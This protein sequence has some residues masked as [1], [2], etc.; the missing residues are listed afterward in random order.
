MRGKRTASVHLPTSR[1]QGNCRRKRK[2]RCRLRDNN[3]STLDLIRFRLRANTKILSC[4]LHQ[5][6]LPT[7]KLSLLRPFTMLTPF[8]L[9]RSR[10]R[11]AIRMFTRHPRHRFTWSLATTTNK[12]TQV[13]YSKPQRLPRDTQPSTSQPSPW[14]SSAIS[15]P[16]SSQ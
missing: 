16:S 15:V 12:T 1:K 14:F 9:G 11:T 4:R 13:F 6:A 10:I 8:V 7:H 2:S 5:K 3:Q